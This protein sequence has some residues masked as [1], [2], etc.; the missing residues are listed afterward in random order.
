LA[1]VGP[2]PGVD[3]HGP[4][5]VL[6]WTTLFSR[7]DPIGASKFGQVVGGLVVIEPTGA[8]LGQIVGGLVVAPP[9]RGG[10]MCALSTRRS[11]PRARGR[12]RPLVVCGGPQPS[13][14]PNWLAR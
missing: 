7:G 12:V 5:R 6:R 14:A 1:V 2:V 9:S 4:L 3:A 10:P 8:G 13:L 11:R